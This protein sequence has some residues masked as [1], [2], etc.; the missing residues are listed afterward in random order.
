MIRVAQATHDT[1]YETTIMAQPDPSTAFVTTP[2]A[3]VIQPR[4]WTGTPGIDP[5]L[6]TIDCAE[7]AMDDGDLKSD[8]ELARRMRST[9]DQVGLVHLVNTHLTDLAIMREFAKL[10]VQKEMIYTGGAN[11]RNRIQPNVYEVGAPLSAWLHYHHEMAYIA[12]STSMLGFLCYKAAPGKGATYV[13]DNL[14]ATDAILAT[15]LG[16]K[17]KDKGI[18]YHRNL[19]DREAFNGKPPI[20][21]YNHWQQSMGTEDPDTAAAI[22]RE[23]G[24]LTDWGPERMLLT[25]YYTSAFEYCPYSDRNVLYASVADDAMWFDSWPMVM[26]LPP[27]QRPLKLTY[28][29]DTEFTREEFALFVDI[30][31]RFGIPI[32]WRQGDI[33]VI[34]N[35]RFAHGRPGIELE[36]GEARE[37]GVLLGETFERQ[38]TRPDK[39]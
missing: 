13:S 19:T 11:P 14:Q 31:D 39:W 3:G 22:A 9:F 20:G 26:Q 30:Y 15:E 32:D 28:G 2:A 37:L 12:H 29:D 1:L 38:E 24:L 6:F 10:V 36:Q 21:V 33:A 25:R 34:C 16:Q 8:S 23:R 35:F 17:L 7:Y 18:C 5:S 4:W 27:E